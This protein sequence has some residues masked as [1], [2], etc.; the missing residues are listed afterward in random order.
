MKITYS[1]GKYQCAL[2]VQ[3][4]REIHAKLVRTRKKKKKKKHQKLTEQNDVA[5][6]GINYM[7]SK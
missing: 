5:I 6:K 3:G 7:Y 1:M 2:K 4:K